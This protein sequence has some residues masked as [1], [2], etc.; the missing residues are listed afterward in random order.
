M[1]ILSLW[2]TLQPLNEY[3]PYLEFQKDEAPFFAYNFLTTNV[4]NS[5]TD[6][7]MISLCAVIGFGEIEDEELC[8][9]NRSAIQWGGFK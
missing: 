5:I 1:Y 7:F 8:E 6:Y 3:Q 2:S 4:N 9:D